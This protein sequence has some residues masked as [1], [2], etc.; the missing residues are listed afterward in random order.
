[1]ADNV[2]TTPIASQYADIRVTRKYKLT[3]ERQ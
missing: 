2:Q 3:D 1:M